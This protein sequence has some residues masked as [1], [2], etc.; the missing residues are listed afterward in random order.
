MIR[1]LYI[2]WLFPLLLASCTKTVPIPLDSADIAA[3]VCVMEGTQKD[4]LLS[5]CAYVLTD[6]LPAYTFEDIRSPVFKDKF[7]PYPLFQDNLEND[8]SYWIKIQLENRLQEAHR[9][10]EWVFYLTNTWSHLE[11]FIPGEDGSWIKETSG[12]L[13]PLS[14]KSFAPGAKGNF[15]KLTLPPNKVKTIYFRGRSE[16]AAIL[17]SL[18]MRLKHIDTFYDELLKTK[19]SNALFIGFLLMMF[20][21]NLIIYFFGK[22][23][24]FIFYSGYLLMIVIYA[25]FSSEDLADWFALF[26]NHPSWLRMM[27]LS[28][29]LAMMCYLAFIRSFLDL[30]KLLPGWDKA[31]K[32]LIYL[33]VPLMILDVAVLLTTNYSYVIE[34]RIVVPYI[35][36]IV[37]LCCLL[38]YPLY[39]TGEKRGYFIIAGVTAICTGALLT[40]LT[41][42]LDTPFTLLFLKVG[43]I[44][45]VLIFSLGLT[46]RQRQQKQAEQAAIF[47][48]KESQLIQ[49]KKALEAGRLQELNEFKSRFY[50]NITHEFRTPLTVI[51]GISET[52]TKHEEEKKL[53]LRNSQ[54][55]L[56]L[57]NQMLDL[58]KLES[59]NL[60]LNEVHQDIL[61]YL[62]YLTESFYSAASQQ[63]IRL[64][65]HSDEASIKMDYDEEKIQQIVYNLLSNALKFT[66]PGGKI[67]FLASKIE[68]TTQ[69][70]LKLKIQDTGIGIPEKEL[71]Y[72]FD[73]FY[74][75]HP[76]RKISGSNSGIGLA[77]TRELVHLMD[78]RIEVQSQEGTGTTFVLYLPIR[79]QAPSPA[80][81]A[82]EKGNPL[83]HPHAFINEKAASDATP[84]DPESAD[85]QMQHPEVLI[86]EDNEDII[87]YITAVLKQDYKVHAVREGASGI[88]F[89]LEHIPDII[90]SDVVMPQKNGYEVCETLKLNEKTSHIPII[91]LTARSEQSDKLAGLKYGADAYLTKPFDREE[92]LIR[93]EKLISIRRRL[94][95]RYSTGAEK[96]EPAEPTIDDIFLQKLQRYIEEEIG[97]SAFGV[98][99]LSAAAELSQMQLYRKLKALTGKTPSQFIRSYRLKKSLEL[100]RTGEWSISEIAYDVGFADPSYFSRVFHKEFGQSPS[101]FIKN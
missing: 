20:F 47:K 3:E 27:K 61:S 9:H 44:L 83:M 59:S 60:P 63:T 18:Y 37:G 62:Q 54:H 48:L 21:Y 92:L 38:L 98:A 74:Q 75:A 6:S 46:Y 67:I 13:L 25:S 28:I 57:I 11:V 10:T 53:I 52:I 89:A 31:F 95:E 23:R 84:L 41:R 2:G 35:L 30:K 73:R 88:A 12:S 56:R 45:E 33:G 29:Y 5:S 93:M 14:T 65:F 70:Y 101:D 16:R 55:L 86:I 4:I 76:S 7:V 22:D 42:L 91:L 50:T 36:S 71:E 78:G 99:Q 69:A 58:S 8:Q 26:A 94:Q 43:T 85:G 77:L 32:W 100:L 90:I 40:V 51:M 15:V 96:T 34:D 64:V 68:E 1:V 19:V 39:K 72:I 66:P 80:K 81:E 82:F 87:N 49:E 17:P 97:N 79:N 24:S